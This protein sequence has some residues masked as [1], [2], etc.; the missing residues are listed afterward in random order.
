MPLQ[1]QLLWKDLK[2]FLICKFRLFT[3]GSFYPNSILPKL[4]YRRYINIDE[5]IEK[6]QMVILRRSD[7]PV[8][9]TFNDLGILRE[10]ALVA[11]DLPGFS[12]NLL[13]ANFK[14]PF[15]KYVPII[16][17]KATERWNGIDKIYLADYINL[18]KIKEVWS[19]IFFKGSD[20]HNLEIPYTKSEDKSI[21][22]VLKK[23]HLKYEVSDS[24]INSSGKAII[25]HVP[26]NLNYWH[27]ELHLTNFNGDI[28]KK[29]SN[30]FDKDISGYLI[31]H[32]LSVKGSQELNVAIDIIPKSFYIS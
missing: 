29:V 4:R 32:V 22:K 21:L 15:I 24:T 28:I 19:P 13:G 14:T 31:S 8:A 18:Y 3:K 23:L 7:K 11:K 12:M 20:M 1:F 17:T 5:L 26:T 10:D 6:Q 16:N 2:N 30:Q 25:K 27:L 9:E